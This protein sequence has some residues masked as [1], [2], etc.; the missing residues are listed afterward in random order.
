[1]ALIRPQ[2]SLMWPASTSEDVVSYVVFQEV[3]GD[4]TYNSPNA[5]VG[6]VNLVALPI[7]GLPAVEGQVVF[8][9][10]AKDRVGNLSDITV[11]VPVLIDVTPPAAPLEL[12]YNIP[13]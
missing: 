9:V 8:G 2:G 7:A 10:A 5:D 4:P 13:T 11:T 1:M 3:G 6:N 12:V